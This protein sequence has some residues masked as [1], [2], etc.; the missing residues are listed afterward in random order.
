MPREDHTRQVPG[1]NQITPVPAGDVNKE[2]VYPTIDAS[3]FM[4]EFKST[5]KKDQYF[6]SRQGKPASELQ[7]E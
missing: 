6:K 4:E 3:K 2:N 1:Q 7:L 5:I